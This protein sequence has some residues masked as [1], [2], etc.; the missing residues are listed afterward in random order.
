VSEEFLDFSDVDS[1]FEKV[2]CEA[3]SESVAVDVF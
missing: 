3:V 1:V 2:C